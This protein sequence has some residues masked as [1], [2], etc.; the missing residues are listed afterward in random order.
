MPDDPIQPPVEEE[1]DPGYLRVRDFL[2]F[3]M[4]LPERA[5]R[6]AAGV[7]TG[8]IRESASLLV[9]QA[10]QNS[11]MYHIFIRQGL[12]FLAED[13]GGVAPSAD[14]DAPP[15]VKNF[16]A[17]KAVGNFI[18]MAGLATI[19]LSPLVV[20][21]VIS[22][23][24]YGSQ[25]YLREVADDL[26]RQ[27][28]IDQDS[29]IHHV[30]DLLDAVAGAAKVTATAFDTPPL[31]VDGLRETVSQ[32]RKA[33]A[34]INPAEVVPQAEVQRLWK[35]IHQTATSQGVDPLAVSAAMTLYSLEKIGTLGRGALSTVRAAV[36][37]FDR[38]VIDYYTDA[39]GD[40]R[41]KGIYASLKETSQPYI[42]AV[43]LNF[44]TGKTTITEDLLTGRLI[45]RTW[46][47]VRRWLGGKPP[48]SEARPPD[49][50]A[51]LPCS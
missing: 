13:V 26:K 46:G 24:A 31:S 48:S 32:T 37:L 29:T 22:D 50:E 21:A 11:K 17:R 10:F 43:W 34:S 8:T 44:S 42:D 18:E 23:V 40:I 20:L 15:K 39:L 12:A 30:D 5:L 19:H 3:G 6:S 33:V 36:T 49:P 41:R 35:E 4:S 25:A 14:P 7:L 38:V 28:I 51:D 9:P 47:A 45:G 2:L 16:V 27:G 1:D